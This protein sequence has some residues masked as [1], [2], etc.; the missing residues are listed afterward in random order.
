MKKLIICFSA[1]S[2]FVF[3]SCVKTVQDNRI[4]INSISAK[5]EYGAQ[6]VIVP[7]DETVTIK[8]NTIILA[9]KKENMHYTFSGYFNG[10]IISKTKN[11]VIRL[12]DAFIEN[13]ANKP[14]ILAESKTEISA[15]KNS[16]NYVSASG[17]GYSRTA[18]V[19]SKRGLLI[20]GGGTLYI[21]GKHSHG[22]EAEDL[23]IKGSGTYYVSGTKNGSAISCKTLVVDPE[24]TFS[25]YLLNS[26]NGIKAEKT[27]DI[28]S[29]T[30]YLYENITALK[31]GTSKNSPDNAHG[32]HLSGGEFHTY[33]NHRL[34]KTE[35]DSYLDSGAKFIQD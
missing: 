1:I 7:M 21:N 29:G 32:I 20:A 28:A 16:I 23:K 22:I 14:A 6:L 26:K 5:S 9:P 25:I 15:A 10:Q 2:A 35:K 8:G 30:F 4:S 18:A 31:T 33:G 19:K 24:K 13:T 11:T 17:H 12:K 34:Y 27:I 3:F